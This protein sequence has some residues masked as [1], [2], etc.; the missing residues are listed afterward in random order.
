MPIPLP[1]AQLD[2]FVLRLDS[3]IRLFDEELAMLSDRSAA[4]MQQLT[5]RKHRLLLQLQRAAR[6]IEVTASVSR[7]LLALV[8]ATASVQS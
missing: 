3:A 6:E 1:E 2:R 5:A 4:L 8:R 7:Y